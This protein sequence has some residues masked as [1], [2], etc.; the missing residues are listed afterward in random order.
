MILKVVL[1]DGDTL[2]DPETGH[3][4]IAQPSCIAESETFKLRTQ[5]PLEPSFG[6]GFTIMTSS[7]NN[8]FP[9][10][11]TLRRV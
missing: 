5:A 7:P 6:C 2:H 3:D 1:A 10:L 4:L 8:T 9:V 11:A